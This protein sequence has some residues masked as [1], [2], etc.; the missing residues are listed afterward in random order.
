MSKISVERMNQIFLE[1]FSGDKGL[2][3]EAIGDGTCTVR[4]KVDQ[5]MVRPGGTLS[6]PFMMGLADTAMWACVM[7]QV[8]EVQ[9]AVTTNLN[10][11]FLSKPPMCDAI[12]EGRMIK[13][14]KRLAVME[15]TLFSVENLHEPVAHATGTYSLPPGGE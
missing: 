11:N 10:I 3:V 2:V 15:V 4:L 8:G 12:A 7:S 6:G 9:L 1:G 13:L 14:G 5:G